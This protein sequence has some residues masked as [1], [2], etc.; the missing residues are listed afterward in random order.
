MP[1]ESKSTP[2][3][4][5]KTKIDQFIDGLFAYLQRQWWLV[6]LVI[7]YIF[8]HPTFESKFVAL[9]QSFAPSWVSFIVW[10]GI[11]VTAL[12]YTYVLCRRRYVISEGVLSWTA[13]LLL[14]WAYYRL[15]GVADYVATPTRIPGICYVDFL[16]FCGGC[17]AFVMWWSH[18]HRTKPKQEGVNNSIRGFEVECPCTYKDN[19]LL[20]RRNEAQDLAEKIFQ[21]DTSNAAFTLGL[22]APW[23]AGKT[24]FMLTMKDYLEKRHSDETILLDFNP[25]MYRKAPNLTQIFFEELSRALAPYSSALASGFT[26]YVDHILDKDDSAWIQ[27][28]ARLLP[29]GFKAKSTSE[30]YEFL[31]K[32]ICKLGRKIV[33]FIDDVDRLDGEELV[34]LFS[35][36]RNS[37][38]SF[39]NMSYILTYDKEYVASQLQ[40]KFDAHT[41]RYMEKIVQVEYLLAKTTPEQLEEALRRELKRIGYCDLWRDI[42]NSGL[43]LSYHLPTLRVIKR[44]CNTLSSRRKVLEGNVALFDWFIIELIRIQY[45]RLFDFLRE[46]YSRVF[47]IQGDK[48][49]I[50]LKEV[51]EHEKSRKEEPLADHPS[52]GYEIDFYKHISEHHESLQIKSVIELLV[53]LWGGDRDA[54]PRQANHGDYIGIYFYGT[55]RA[56]EIDDHEF[57]IGISQSIEKV[58]RYAD[59]KFNQMQEQ[60]LYRK[61]KQVNIDSKEKG[62]KILSTL[63]YIASK[64]LALVTR[65]D[66]DDAIHALNKYMPEGERKEKQ[67]EIFARPD[68]RLGVLLYLIMAIRYSEPPEQDRY[69]GEDK[70]ALYFSSAELNATKEELFLKYLRENKSTHPGF[71]YILWR[72]CRPL[73]Q[74]GINQWGRPQ[75]KAIPSP[76]IDKEMKQVVEENLKAVIPYFIAQQGKN[77]ENY[78]YTL[79]LPNPIWKL[80]ANKENPEVESFIEFISRQDSNTS[81]VIKEFQEFLKVWEE[82]V[83]FENTDDICIRFKFDH[84]TPKGKTSLLTPHRSKPS[85]WHEDDPTEMY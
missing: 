29:Q 39:P 80:Y 19:D 37:S 50:I 48:R 60:S 31:K 14:G 79:L 23:G 58:L 64:S 9:L 30:Q 22:T 81:P 69:T 27:L 56:V 62:E 2:S 68:I 6:A 16:P 42:K 10:C 67:K 38:L 66:I 12:A 61:V 15:I 8:F 1:M 41:Y 72:E 78:Y 35:L 18:R 5:P 17:M 57:Q 26:R 28:G 76:Q 65:I 49:S 13:F 55:L 25:W 33:I 46:N 47:Y 63:F 45:P 44:I 85:R 36:I 71:C 32:E 84:I 24:S 83:Y 54:K 40:N 70:G 3:S 52:Y 34:E 20:G 43:Q 77:S 74:D 59:L 73:E 7:L 11:I 21:T 82:G 4:S 53:T 51:K 75:L